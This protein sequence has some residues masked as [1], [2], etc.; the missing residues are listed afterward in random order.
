M[1]R[2]L[3]YQRNGI[4]T[5]KLQYTDDWLIEQ[6]GRKR[7][8]SLRTRNKA[9]AQMLAIPYVVEHRRRLLAAE[10]RRKRKATLVNSGFL[11]P[12]G[13]TVLP[14]GRT[15]MA[16]EHIAWIK[17]LDGSMR[18]VRNGVSLVSSYE[19]DAD[20]GP[21]LPGIGSPDMAHFVAAAPK[22]A[23]KIDPDQVIFD[24]WVKERK[25]E[26]YI[27]NEAIKAFALF[28]TVNDNM[29]FQDAYRPDAMKLVAALQG[30]GVKNATI[31]KHLSH[32]KS[33]CG[34]A[35]LNGKLKHNPFARVALDP[36]EDA[37]VRD[38]FSEEQ[39]SLVRANLHHFDPEVAKLWTLLATT[40]MRLSEPW[41]I[42]R[43]H[44]ERGIRKVRVG[45]KTESSDRWI[46]LPQD[47][48]ERYPEKIDGPLFTKSSRTMGKDL[49]KAFRA[50]GLK[51]KKLVNHSLRHRA[52]DRLRA[53]E[54]P[55]DI[56]EWICGHEEITAADGYG[57]GPPMTV[58][59]P[60]IDLIG[61]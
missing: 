21:P 44:L 24:D 49:L 18:E 55:E 28:K 61:Y 27:F 5:V 20:A 19:P 53:E 16:D 14:D 23:K 40:G 47:F 38:P 54:C 58:L 9:E 2:D 15:V 25:P 8:I 37:L 12:I 42:Q 7:E 13:R 22:P 39:M 34:I 43:E 6:Y 45:T 10:Q 33:M 51:D 3:I 36:K 11:Y 52:K 1:Q 60:W 17:D 35:V 4:W 32:M 26:K 46:P 41:D 50:L 30:Q 48:L 31:N 59:K 56:Q 57:K 29:F